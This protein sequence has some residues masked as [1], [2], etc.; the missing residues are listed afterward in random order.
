[1]LGLTEPTQSQRQV[2]SGIYLFHFF[3]LG[4][5]VSRTPIGV[6]VEWGMDPLSGHCKYK[7]L[8]YV[9]LC[10]GGTGVFFLNIL[11]TA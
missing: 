7:E 9:L 4:T 2:F 8:A 6:S 10:V 1:V 3:P 11:G 5:R